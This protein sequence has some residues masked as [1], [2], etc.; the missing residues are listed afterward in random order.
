MAGMEFAAVR[1]SRAAAGRGAVLVHAW[2]GIRDV[3]LDYVHPFALRMA[4]LGSAAVGLAVL[5]AWTMLIVAPRIV[6][7]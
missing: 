5:A 6:F 3:V 1:R 7:A 2:V 4:V